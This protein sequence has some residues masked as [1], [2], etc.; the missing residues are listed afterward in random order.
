MPVLVSLAELKDYLGE[1]P[2]F[3]DDNVLEGLIDGVESLF[4]SETGRTLGSYQGAGLARTE[5]HDGTGSRDLFLD[6]P[7]TALTSVKLG[8]DVAVPDET[9]TIADRNVIVYG[10]GQRRITRTDGGTFGRDRH[11]RYVHVVY[12]F[13]ADLPDNALLAIKSVAAL[14]YRRRGS[15]A[16]K[17]ETLGSFYSHTLVDEIA[18]TDPFW[19]SAVIANARAQFV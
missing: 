12:D 9:L 15:E 19:R 16:E 8:H 18:T 3:E 4:A 11:P 5:V 17:S 13:G 1:V 6:Y 7:I 2:A 14:A 10:A